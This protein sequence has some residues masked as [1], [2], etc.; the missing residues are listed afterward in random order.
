LN[1]WLLLNHLDRQ[2]LSVNA[3]STIESGYSPSKI[4]P[5]ILDIYTRAGVELNR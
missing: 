2:S 3:R 1:E 4:I 5:K